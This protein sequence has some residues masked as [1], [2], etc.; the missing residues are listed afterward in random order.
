MDAASAQRIE[1]EFEKIDLHHAE[2]HVFLCIGPDCCASEAG[3]ESWE[4]LKKEIKT[5]RV[6]VLRT[7]AACFRI[8]TGGP[9]ML[10]YPEGIWY[11]AVTPERCERIVR[12]HLLGGQPVREWIVRIHPLPPTNSAIQP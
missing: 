10:V 5:H 4:T 6:S 12:E 9:W 8:C 2:R 3:L 11:G 1:N 7:K